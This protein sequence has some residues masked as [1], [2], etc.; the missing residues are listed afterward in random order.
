MLQKASKRI[1]SALTFMEVESR[2]QPETNGKS[3]EKS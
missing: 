2:K 3:G 1:L